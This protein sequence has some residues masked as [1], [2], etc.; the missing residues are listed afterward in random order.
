MFKPPG[1]NKN[2]R[3]MSRLLRIQVFTFHLEKSEKSFKCNIGQVQK[4]AWSWLLWTLLRQVPVTINNAQDTLLL[5]EHEEEI[6]Y[7]EELKLKLK[8]K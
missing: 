8:L 5:P 2:R 7:M 4:Q 3:E 1:R 6:K